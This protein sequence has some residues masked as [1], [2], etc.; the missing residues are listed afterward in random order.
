MCFKT[1]ILLIYFSVGSQV[2]TVMSDNLSPLVNLRFQENFKLTTDHSPQFV[3]RLSDADRSAVVLTLEISSNFMLNVGKYAHDSGLGL[4][5]ICNT[6]FSFLQLC[7]STRLEDRFYSL[8]AEI[9]HQYKSKY[10]GGRKRYQ[11]DKKL[12]SV[13]VF[14]QELIDV[15][16]LSFTLSNFDSEKVELEQKCK[17]LYESLLNEKSKSEEQSIKIE[18]LDKENE[19]LKSRNKSL[20]NYVDVLSKQNFNNCGKKFDDLQQRQKL[21]KIKCLETLAEKALSFAETF[22]LKPLKLQCKSESGKDVTL[23]LRETNSESENQ[24]YQ[25][26][27]IDEKEKLK[28]LIF[29]LDKFCV[30]DAAYYEL[31]MLF[32]ELPRKYLVVQ[33]REDIY[34]MYNIERLPGNKPGAMLSLT[35][36]IERLIKFEV[37]QS[38]T[39]IKKIKIKFSG[40]GAKVSRISNF[41]IFSISNLKEDVNLSVHQLNTVAVV[42]CDENYDNLRD[43]CKPLFDQLT[44]FCNTKSITVDGQIYSL[45]FFVGGDMKFLQILLGLGGSTGDYACPWCKVHKNDRHDLSKEWDFYHSSNL[46]RSIEEINSLAGQ[47]KNKYGVKHK[48]LLSVSVDHFMPDELHLMLRITDV[49][50]RNVIDDCKDKEDLAKKMDR[51]LSI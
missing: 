50:L 5:D 22:G 48:P 3:N 19:Y 46:F 25:D 49:L 24:N 10:H 39:E 38:T 4:I 30:S 33:D 42:Q 37:N 16:S 9:K 45:D 47:S 23:K 36:E 28:Q 34:K 15:K 31:T 40:D 1:F 14:K 32:G 44:E 8:Y 11:Y 20:S 29:L 2:S 6:Q 7:N 17:E 51:R 43:T 21:R 27:N 18:T 35:S 41:V 26:L 12:H 13:A